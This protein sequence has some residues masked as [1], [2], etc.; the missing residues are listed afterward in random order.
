VGDK[1]HTL[2]NGLQPIRWIGSRTLG[3]RE[4]LAN[5][6]IRPVLIPEGICGAHTPLFVSP[7]H[8]MLVDTDSTVG[9]TAFARAKHLAEAKGPVRIAHGKKRVT[10]FHLMFDSH[11]VIFANGAASESFYPG[12]YALQMFSDD[13]VKELELVIPGFSEMPVEQAYGAS[14]RPY[15]KRREVLDGLVLRQE[16]ARRAV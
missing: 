11:Q 14:A 2:D 15:M 13:V 12:E 7:L 1:V 6:T 9:G 8:G 16:L 5:P 10:Y 4:L 3:P